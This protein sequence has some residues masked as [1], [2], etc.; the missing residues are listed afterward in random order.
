MVSA[1][2]NLP[3]TVDNL[4]ID[5]QKFNRKKFRNILIYDHFTPNFA[6]NG[7]P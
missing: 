1:S 3:F 5:L 4:F 6:A 2:F 7:V